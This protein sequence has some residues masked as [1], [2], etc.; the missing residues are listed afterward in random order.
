[1]PLRLTILTTGRRFTQRKSVKT[2]LLLGKQ[3]NT[4]DLCAPKRNPAR[5]RLPAQ[6]GRLAFAALRLFD[7]KAQPLL[8]I[9]A[10]IPLEDFYNDVI[11]KAQ[12]GLGL[13]D[14]QLAKQANISVAE[15]AAVKD[16]QSADSALLKKLA[17]ALDL[18]APALIAMAQQ[19]WAPLPVT[20]DGVAQFNTV[21]E[22]M[23]VNAYLVW[24]PQ[25]RKAAAFDSGTDASVILDFVKEKELSL[26]QVFL[27]HTHVDHVSDLAT[28]RGSERL[29]LRACVAEP[30]E[31]A[32]L[33][34]CGQ[35][36]AIGNLRVETR[37]TRGHSKGG[38]TYVIHGLAR[39]VAVVGDALFSSSMGG[40]AVSYIDALETNRREIFTLPDDT[41]V[42]PGHGPLTTVGEEKA[43]NPFYPEFKGEG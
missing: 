26:E 13:E 35:V 25:T 16:G 32:E 7:R 15:L 10:T 12:R 38:V 39:P 27:T 34:A 43:H 21:Y 6:G 42:C 22:D 31:G 1:M 2:T 5:L 24:D 18:D 29:P 8:Q 11:G 30:W 33:F 40:G 20:L 17:T 41:I 19:Q 28:L 9:M 3:R 23:T 14:A 37:Q 4:P 36:F